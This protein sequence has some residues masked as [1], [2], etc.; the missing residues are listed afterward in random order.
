MEK[1]LA[2]KVCV[3]ESLSHAGSDGRPTCL[4]DDDDH[5]DFNN[6]NLVIDIREV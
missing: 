5:D 2:M 4:D 1:N 6:N 3:S